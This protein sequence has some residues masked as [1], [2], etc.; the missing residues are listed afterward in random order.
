MIQKSLKIKVSG[1][2]A[3]YVGVFA[4]SDNCAS[5]D[6]HTVDAIYEA[7][8]YYINGVV[9]YENADCIGNAIITV[10]IQDD[11][12]CTQTFTIDVDDPCNLQIS[13]LYSAQPY[14]FNA[15][16]LG[17]D[18]NRYSWSYDRNLFDLEASPTNELRL[19]LKSSNPPTSTKIGL[20][21][22]D[23]NGCSEYK[24]LNYIFCKPK[25]KDDTALGTCVGTLP[26]TFPPTPFVVKYITPEIDLNTSGCTTDPIDWSTLQLWGYPAE[27]YPIVDED[28]V[29]FVFNEDVD[30]NT[31]FTV[32]WNVKTNSGVT[33]STGRISLRVE[34]CTTQDFDIQ[35]ASYQIECG[36]I[37]GDTLVIPLYELI[38][39]GVT[40]DWSTFQILSVPAPTSGSIVQSFD[41]LGR[42]VINYEI[43]ALTGTDSFQFYLCDVE[44]RCSTGSV[45]TVLLDCAQ[46]PTAGAISACL[47]C[48]KSITVDAVAAVVSTNGG[49]IDP[50][51]VQIVNVLFPLL[52][53]TPTTDGKIVIEAD[54]SFYTAGVPVGLVTYKIS[55]Q[56]GQASSTA[57]IT[58]T[59]YCAGEDTYV[60]W[61]DPSGTGVFNPFSNLGGNK[62]TG[63]LWSLASSPTGVAPTSPATYNANITFTG[64]HPDGEYV[65]QYFVTGGS[66]P[67][68]AQ[69][70]I[71]INR[72]T[73]FPVTNDAC[74]N[75]KRIP[76][77]NTDYVLS[78]ETLVGECP[79]YEDASDSG[80]AKPASWTAAAIFGDKW[81]KLDYSPPSTGTIVNMRVTI[82]GAPHGVAGIDDPL[83]EIFEPDC[84]TTIDDGAGSGDSVYIDIG[85]NFAVART[86]YI[87]V[88]SHSGD[89][90]KFDI[91]ID[92]S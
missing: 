13:S 18:N 27:A 86:F 90:G 68:N 76:T 83:L 62:S 3:P 66:D 20:T 42:P 14:I 53:A 41:S 58:I 91:E 11:N 52:T 50:S 36:S 85:G 45:L 24:E 6:E 55:N 61:C 75:A 46:A 44:G 54:D 80:V 65:Y 67:C 72:Q 70:Q 47:A 26:L 69:A 79:G 8:E 84:A 78:D 10:T 29:I 7:G 81:Y 63:G 77:A 64:S 38:P 88:A 49:I 74:A 34:D 28:K 39:F 89:E 32:A 60:T 30:L 25:A 59:G 40:V 9:N 37:V 19:R 1:G 2:E 21:V 73:Q 56:N 31:V 15:I 35:D 12:D 23:S 82:N 33:S 48:S 22:T 57:T 92:F 51:S 17:G 87:R 16:V 5:F 43:P 4:T 71:T